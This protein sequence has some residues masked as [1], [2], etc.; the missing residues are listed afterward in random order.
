MLTVHIVPEDEIETHAKRALNL[1]RH[2]IVVSEAK[3]MTSAKREARDVTAMSRDMDVIAIVCAAK[4]DP[5][6]PVLTMEW[7]ENADEVYSIV[8][9]KTTTLKLRHSPYMVV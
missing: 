9:S 3:D 6:R 1:Y 2:K 7:K 4:H 5:Y 8:G